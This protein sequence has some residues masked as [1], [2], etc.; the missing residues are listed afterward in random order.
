MSETR[1]RAIAALHAK[2]AEEEAAKKRKA[3]AKKTIASMAKSNMRF[4]RVKERPAPKS[5]HR[6]TAVEEPERAER[7]PRFVMGKVE[8]PPSPPPLGRDELRD[9]AEARTSTFPRP[10]GGPISSYYLDA[11][12]AEERAAARDAEARRREEAAEAAKSPVRKYR[13]ASID[14]HTYETG[15][16]YSARKHRE[17]RAAEVEE[18]KAEAAKRKERIDA[19]HRASRKALA[20]ASF[21]Y[22]L[23]GE[24]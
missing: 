19:I 13:K 20:L 15:D 24:K 2:L 22:K 1:D 5:V 16:V 3:E 21:G 23:P 4:G 7:L 10:I 12:D 17:E 9:I 8:R 14:D 11:R 6:P 18:A